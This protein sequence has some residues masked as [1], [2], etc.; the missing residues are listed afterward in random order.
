[1]IT[2][3]PR[4]LS[5]VLILVVLTPRSDVGAGQVK[6][7]CIADGQTAEDVLQVALDWACGAGGANCSMIQPNKPCYL[8][9]TVEDHASY[10]FN[11]YWQKHKHLGGTC[12]FNAAAMVTD[13][14]PSHDACQFESLP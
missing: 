9:N 8:P 3:V 5:L 10:A 2:G 12:Y 11:S 14:N 4:L 7:W 1:M 13:L 6:Q